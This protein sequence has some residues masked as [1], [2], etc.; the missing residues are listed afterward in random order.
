M[1]EVFKVNMGEKSEGLEGISRTSRKIEDYVPGYRNGFLFTLL[2]LAAFIIWA[3][4]NASAEHEVYGWPFYLIIIAVSAFSFI[5]GFVVETHRRTG[6]LVLAGMF[7]SVAV[8]FL[9][10]VELKL[11]G[12]Y[13]AAWIGLLSGGASALCVMWLRKREKWNAEHPYA[14]C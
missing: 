5:S 8:V 1:A 2:I 6:T 11:A 14:R 10:S 13:F 4:M 12:A 3:W 9:I 7:L